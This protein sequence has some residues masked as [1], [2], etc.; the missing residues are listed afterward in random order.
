[1]ESTVR[2][3]PYCDKQCGNESGLTRHIKYTP[4]CLLRQKMELNPTVVAKKT[5]R[6]ASDFLRFTTVEPTTTTTNRLTTIPYHIFTFPP[7]AAMGR[8]N[9]ENCRDS[10]CSSRDS[11]PYECNS[12][13]DSYL[14]EGYSISSFGDDNDDSFAS[15]GNEMAATRSLIRDSFWK[16][17]QY[18]QK[19]HSIFPSS[20]VRSINTNPK[21]VLRQLTDP[22]YPI[23]SIIVGKC[24]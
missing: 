10:E 3:C 17:S 18:A 12:V 22:F 7:S 15:P 6:S 21:L 5:K 1:M 11:I 8:T 19:N 20:E 24:H 16:Y 13:G 4:N 9:D 2:I 14:P 23:I